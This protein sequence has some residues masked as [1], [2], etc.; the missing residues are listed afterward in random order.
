MRA[1]WP[2][3]FSVRNAKLQASMGTSTMEWGTSE[4]MLQ[5]GLSQGRC[6]RARVYW[7]F[8]PATPGGLPNAA[9]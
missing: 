6:A 1:N 5:V 4:S 8:E 2:V 9:A 3:V 7:R